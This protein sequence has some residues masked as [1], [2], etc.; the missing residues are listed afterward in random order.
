MNYTE[1]NSLDNDNK[2]HFQRFI[3][4]RYFLWNDL[5]ASLGVEWS[6]AQFWNANPGL[7]FGRESLTSCLLS[8]DYNATVEWSG[9]EWSEIKS[10]INISPSCTNEGGREWKGPNKTLNVLD[11]TDFIAHL[12]A[13]WCL[14]LSNVGPD[15]R[16]GIHWKGWK[17][18]Y[19]LKHFGNNEWSDSLCLLIP[20]YSSETDAVIDGNILSYSRDSDPDRNWSL[21]WSWNIWLRFPLPT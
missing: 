8:Y 20:R 15:L 1:Y 12:V 21:I 13:A 18:K 16:R 5:S 6:L 3:I 4:S 10:H 11:K 19:F 2:I 9:V 17:V 7:L 14:N